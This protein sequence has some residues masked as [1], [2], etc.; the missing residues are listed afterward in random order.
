M[1]DKIEI[2]TEKD[3][4]IVTVAEPTVEE[5]SASAEVVESETAAQAAAT[6]AASTQQDS[7]KS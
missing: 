4:A 1:G 5:V 6:S 2:I 3:A 7:K